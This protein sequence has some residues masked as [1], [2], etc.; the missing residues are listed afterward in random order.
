MTYKLKYTTLFLSLCAALAACSDQDVLNPI[1]PDADKTPIELKVGDNAPSTRAVVID[2]KGK[3]TAFENDTRLHLLM[4]SE[5]ADNSSDKKYTVTYGLANG[6]GTPPKNVTTPPTYSTI[7]FNED[8]KVVKQ[9]FKKEDGTTGEGY[10]NP[11]NETVNK[12]PI[13]SN[14]KDGIT[15]Y[16]DDAHARKSKLSIYGFCINGTVLPFGAPWNQ[17]IDGIASNTKEIDTTDPKTWKSGVPSSYTIGAEDGSGNKIKW[18]IGDHS[19]SYGTQTF[20]SVL[21]K[22]D[23]CYSNNITGGNVLKF[24]NKETGKFDSGVIEFHRAMS[25]ITVLI[26][27]GNGFVSPLVSSFKFA[28]DTNIKMQGFNKKGYLDLEKGTWSDAPESGEWTTI[29]NAT[30][31]GD[32]YY[33]LMAFVIPGNDLNGDSDAASK[34]AMVFTID[35]NEYKLS[36]QDLLAAIKANTDNQSVDSY[37]NP[38]GNVKEE[39]LTDGTKLKAG[40]NYEFTLTVGKTAIDKITASIVDWKTVTASANP[41]NALPLTITME[42]SAGTSSVESPAASRLFKSSTTTAGLSGVEKG[43]SNTSGQYFDLAKGNGVQNT[44]WYWPSNSTYYHF[45]TVSPIQELT[46]DGDSESNYLTMIGGAINNTDTGNN[47]YIWGAPFK[48]KHSESTHEITYNATNGYNHDDYLYPA[49]GPTK[50]TIHITQFHMMTD[51]EINLSTT[52]DD[53][54]DAD[55]VDLTNATV[56][57]LNYANKANLMIGIGLV[58]GWDDITS[59]QEIT[60]SDTKF[61]WRTVPQSLS[62]GDN[63]ND[64]VGIKIVLSDGNVYEIKDLSILPVT[65]TGSSDTTIGRWEPGTKYV[66]NLVLSKSKIE[67]ITATVVDWK[68]VTTTTSQPVVIQ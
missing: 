31:T 38:T 65:I 1:V 54:N 28:T 21:Y 8:T 23:V 12:N 48:E 52:T 42:T 20:L 25:L 68:T 41:D 64:K 3:V 10:L 37:N 34:T 67:S 44:G 58:N 55:N 62:R 51:L 26:K 13:E 66:Y 32:A 45:R 17:K 39:Y 36:K 47:D 14:S 15:R 6:S 60:R 63:A 5:N 59:S 19:A 61:T 53:G 7:S 24:S 35:G 2:G 50:S 22:D 18:T 27:P 30:A 40:I 57:L 4:V 16:W 43:Y 56:S 33:T 29:C 46:K 49:I 11:A 9:T